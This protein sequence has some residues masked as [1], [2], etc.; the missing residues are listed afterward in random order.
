MMS[1]GFAPKVMQV[2]QAWESV[3]KGTDE[4]PIRRVATYYTLQGEWLADYDHWGPKTCPTC[5]RNPMEA[6]KDG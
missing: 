3:G 6:N 2:I 5:S 4:D 1:D